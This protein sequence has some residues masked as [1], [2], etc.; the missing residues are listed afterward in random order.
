[1][2]EYA[3]DVPIGVV[4]AKRYRA[5]AN[6]GVEQARR[7]AAKLGL[8]FAYATNGRQIVEIDYSGT[9]P[10]IR[11]IDRFPTPEE[12]WTRYLA[13]QQADSSVGRCGAW[14]RCRA[15]GVRALPN[16]ILEKL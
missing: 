11:E 8:S 1:M 7:Y 16:G 2:L 5:D 3:P 10:T 15:G 9:A 14:C 4:E 12:L 13:D 6:D